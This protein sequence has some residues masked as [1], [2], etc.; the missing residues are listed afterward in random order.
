MWLPTGYVARTEFE[1]RRSRFVTLLARTDG[2]E[3]ARLAIA[4][5]RRRF[6]DAR[7]H[8]TAFIVDVP[9]ALAVERSSDDGEPAGT[10]GMPML[11]V[12]RG[13]GLTNATAVVTR[14]FGGIRLGTGGLVRA[15]SRS[16]A[17]ALAV[18]PRVR[19]VTR[20][21]TTLALDHADAGRVRS[22][23]ESR[24]VVVVQVDYGARATFTLTHA[25]GA[26]LAAVVA[27]ATH[28]AGVLEPAGVCVVEEPVHGTDTPS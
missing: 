20:T 1:V 18:A 19:P 5:E 4:E 9:G 26:A 3:A 23:L 12:L 15:Y 11:D 22:E 21:L 6:P 16:V 10:A 17:S 28:G 13:S 25:D 24:G 14:W 8:C 7:H 2:E 27:A